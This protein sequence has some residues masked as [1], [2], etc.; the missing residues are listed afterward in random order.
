MAEQNPK[1]S[2][3][4]PHLEKVSKILLELVAVI[5]NEMNSLRDAEKPV[6]ALQNLTR[7]LDKLANRVERE[8]TLE[9]DRIKPLQINPLVEI[10]AINLMRQVN[11]AARDLGMNRALP[12]AYEDFQKV[13]KEAMDTAKAAHHILAQTGI[14]ATV[15]QPGEPLKDKDGKP[16]VGGME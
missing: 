1:P 9:A 3:K 11:G 13:V 12:K 7:S 4:H 14:S 8:A 15:V 16:L 5:A 2:S 6:E 10:T